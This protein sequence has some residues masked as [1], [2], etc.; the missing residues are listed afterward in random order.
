MQGEFERR[1]EATRRETREKVQK[2][3]EKRYLNQQ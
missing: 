1:I 2:V 3:L